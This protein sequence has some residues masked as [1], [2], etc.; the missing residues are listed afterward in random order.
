MWTDEAQKSF[1]DV[2]GSLDEMLTALALP[3][4]E[5]KFVLDTDASTVEISGDSTPRAAVDR[6]QS[7]S[8]Q[9]TMRVMH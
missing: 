4:S 7:T 8:D 1:E 5:G 9:F 3:A 6:S 2:T